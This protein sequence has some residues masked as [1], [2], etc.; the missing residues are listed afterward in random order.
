ME[1]T[2]RPWDYVLVTHGYPEPRRGDIVSI[3]PG[4]VGSQRVVKRVAG[5]PGDTVETSA[6]TAVVPEGHVWVTGDNAAVS[7]DSRFFGSVPAS[8]I[9]GRAVAVY[10]PPSRLRRL[11]SPGQ[12]H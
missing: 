1:P 12:R 7:L 5:L 11:D 8:D 2:L 10:W 4:V 6:G 3:R 9:A